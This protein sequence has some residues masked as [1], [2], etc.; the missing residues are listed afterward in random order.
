MWNRRSSA[1][2]LTSWL[3]YLWVSTIQRPWDMA[4]TG[5]VSAP[6]VRDFFKIARAG[7]PP[8]PF[9]APPDIKL[10]H[11]DLKSGLPAGPGRPQGHHG[12]VQAHRS[13]LL[14]ASIYGVP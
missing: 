7:Q 2:R 14:F 11:V 5:N 12:G 9:R 13:P 3:A 8:I 10:V 4:E 6:V 1:S